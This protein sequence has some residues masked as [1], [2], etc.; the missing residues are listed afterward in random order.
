M[1]GRAL[2]RMAPALLAVAMAVGSVVYVVD[3]YMTQSRIHNVIFIIPMAALAVLL[4]L[5]ALARMAMRRPAAQPAPAAAP[6]GGDAVSS[7]AVA[8][9]MGGLILY[10][11]AIPWLGFDGATVAYIAASLVLLGE[12]RWWFVAGFSGGLGLLIAW[13][14][15]NAARVP[16]PMLIL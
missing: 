7:L 4:A 13:L 10:A 14:L 2:D 15:L 12:R 16:A 5:I 9:L 8:G 3:A 6:A 1:T 11:V